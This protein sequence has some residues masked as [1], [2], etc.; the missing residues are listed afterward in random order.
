MV[1]DL[2]DRFEYNP[3]PNMKSTEF[4]GYVKAYNTRMLKYFKENGME[5][6]VAA[7]KSGMQEAMKF[8]VK[9]DEIPFKDFDV[10]VGGSFDDNAQYFVS[11]YDGEDEAPTFLYFLDG[12]QSQKC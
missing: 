6:R 11:Y 1:I 3:I 10:Y 5:D 12:L 8:I 2:L 9:N 7:F 4:V